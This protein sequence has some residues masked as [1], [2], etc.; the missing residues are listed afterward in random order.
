MLVLAVRPVPD[1]LPDRRLAE[2]ASDDRLEL[3]AGLERAENRPPCVYR[4]S[5]Q[6]MFLLKRGRG[7]RRRK[8]HITSFDPLTGETSWRPL[9]GVRVRFNMTSNVPF[10]SVCRRCLKAAGRG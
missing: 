4:R 2:A 6:V 7:A 1:G 9:C 3:E 8:A 5:P 10:V